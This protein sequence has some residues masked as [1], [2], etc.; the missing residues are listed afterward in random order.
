MTQKTMVLEY[1]R[2]GNSITSLK[3]LTLFGAFRLADIIFKLRRAGVPVADAWE[4]KGNK[5]Y[6]RY[7]IK[8]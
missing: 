8:K 3:A 1:L 2:A 7:F 5:K 4:Y 6:K